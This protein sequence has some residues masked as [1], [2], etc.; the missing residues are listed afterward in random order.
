VSEEEHEHHDHDHDHDGHDHDH[1]HDHTLITDRLPEGV[2]VVDPDGSEV[3]FKARTIFGLLPVNGVFERFSGEM[4]VDPDG[5]AHGTLVVEAASVGTG[6][7]K[8]DEQL[9]S[10]DFFAALEHPQITFT[11]D[12]FESTGEDHLDVTGSL[13]I[14]DTTI[15][16]SFT[17]YAIAHGDHLH[18]E[19]RATIDHE[20]AGLGWF[21]PG[22]V[23]K[24]VRTEIA[25]TLS[26]AG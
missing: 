14:R 13:R 19:G 16:L 15:P 8:R 17:A 3:L 26:R 18:L 22:I 25:L 6:I 7:R 1:D 9:R 5:S 4:T 2:W 24:R 23:G 20:A 10:A 21:K 11:L 12:G